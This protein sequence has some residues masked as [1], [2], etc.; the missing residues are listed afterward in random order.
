MAHLEKCKANQV[1]GL[2]LH[3]SRAS[4][5]HSNEDIDIT[6]THLNYNLAEQIQPLRHSEFMQKRLSEVKYI[7]RAD[8][9]VM[10]SWC[11][12]L[13]KDFQGDERAFFESAF[14]F[15]AEKYGKQ[16]IISAYVH[17]DETTPHL[18]FKFMPIV[19][20]KD[21]KERLCF[22]KCV[23]RK[24]YKNFH[25]ELKK[26]LEK[27]LGVPCNVLNGATE[28]GNRTVQEMKGEQLKK[29]NADLERS[30]SV[31]NAEI[32]EKRAKLDKI[33]ADI[34]KTAKKGLFG[35]SAIESA[36][37]ILEREE[38]LL[39]RESELSKREQSHKEYVDNM[40]Y[41]IGK[42]QREIQ[43][44]REELNV[45]V[46]EKAK[47]IQNNALKKAQK[48]NAQ[49]KESLETAKQILAE[50]SYGNVSA[51]E[52]FERTQKQQKTRQIEC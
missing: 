7:K 34:T 50:C 44:S 24:D 3:D 12:T 1:H 49:L 31:L 39:K 18:H 35:A 32:S 4:E 23:T 20:D 43:K 41:A 6:R 15:M 14:N 22:D 37:R 52:V 19:T 9:N 5:G 29:E 27:D 25:P 16:N 2:C 28:G 10:A 51:L 42:T 33:D 11:V 8:V 26:H 36:K 21:G 40:S 17:M 13:P 46:Y 47:E 30:V 38:E 45:L 48:E